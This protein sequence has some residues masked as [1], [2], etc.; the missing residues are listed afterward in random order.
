MGLHWMSGEING[1]K[2]KENALTYSLKIFCKVYLRC[3]YSYLG[4]TQK[5]SNRNVLCQQWKAALK[6]AGSFLK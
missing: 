4:L 2:P 5:P 6:S 1:E 3:L